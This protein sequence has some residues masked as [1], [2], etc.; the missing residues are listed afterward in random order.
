MVQRQRFFSSTNSIQLSF[1]FS[2][3]CPL[4]P[5]PFV[6]FPWPS[7]EYSVLALGD[8]PCKTNKEVQW[9]LIQYTHLPHQIRQPK[10]T[11]FDGIDDR[12]SI[13]FRSSM[14][15]RIGCVTEFAWHHSTCSW[16]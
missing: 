15:Q 11:A 8:S 1:S 9:W 16:R 12:C 4:G 10:L 2:C 5:T 3:K 7:T 14:L 13:W 6:R